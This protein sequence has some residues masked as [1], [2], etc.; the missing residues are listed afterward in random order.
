VITCGLAASGK[1]TLAQRLVDACGAIGIRSDIERKRLHHLGARDASRSALNSG[2]YSADATEQ[3]YARVAAVARRV[4]AA[5]YL[6]I[7]DGAFLKKSQRERLRTVA[8]DL[9][10]PFGI[11]EAVAS[12]ETLRR[13]IADRGRRR[14]DASEADLPVLEE[15]IRTA[16]E[17]TSDEWPLAIRYDTELDRLDLSCLRIAQFALTGPAS[18]AA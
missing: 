4:A 3:T 17:L 18:H 6:T 12:H 5:G 13:R 2:I 15:Q 7:C 11:V 8:T 14:D 9:A 16:E 1:T 10:I